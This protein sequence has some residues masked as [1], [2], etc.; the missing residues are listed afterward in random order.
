MAVTLPKESLRKQAHGASEMEW[1]EHQ[2]ERNE[3]EWRQARWGVYFFIEMS[4][5]QES[6]KKGKMKAEPGNVPPNSL[7]FFSLFS[8]FFFLFLIVP[9]S[10]HSFCCSNFSQYSHSVYL[11]AQIFVIGSDLVG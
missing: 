7:L 4:G 8:F 3:A 10:F 2:P 5:N 6:D 1:S 11:L 9:A